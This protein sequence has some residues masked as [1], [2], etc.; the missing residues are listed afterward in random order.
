[1][2]RIKPIPKVLVQKHLV[3]GEI[4]PCGWCKGTGKKKNDNNEVKKCWHCEGTGWLE[5]TG[6]SEMGNDVR[7]DGAGP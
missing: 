2:P 5:R 1:M 6:D 3:F 4:F 7:D